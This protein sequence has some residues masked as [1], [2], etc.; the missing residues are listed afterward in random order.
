MSREQLT[1]EVMAL[2]LAERVSLAQDLWQSIE[3][4]CLSATPDEERE[5]LTEA[6]RRDAALSSGAAVGRT[7]EQV[8][9]TMRRAIE[10]G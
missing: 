6:Q 7:H 10:C 8:M 2:P 4:I 1:Q 3:G 5:T 9:E